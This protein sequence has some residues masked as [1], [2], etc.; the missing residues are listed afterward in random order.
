MTEP[1]SQPGSSQ[2]EE[3]P[4]GLQLNS[5]PP[6]S[7]QVNRP[8]NQAGSGQAYL[9]PAGQQL[10]YRARSLAEAHLGKIL[11]ADRNRRTRSQKA[12]QRRVKPILAYLPGYQHLLEE[13][14]RRFR[15]AKDTELGMSIAAE[16][17]LDNAYIVLQA[18]REMR[19]DLPPHY[20]YELPYLES[21]ILRGYPRVYA[22]AHDLIQHENATIDPDRIKRY[23]RAYQAVD[24]GTDPSA[25]QV[26]SLL[27]MGELWALPA[28]LRFG[29]LETLATC[30]GGITAQLNPDEPR[31]VPMLRIHKDLTGDQLVAN[32]VLSLRGLASQDWKVFFEDTSLVE[33]VLKSEPAGVYPRMDFETRDQYRKAVEQLARLTG[34]DEREVSATGSQAG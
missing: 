30:V 8:P 16:W 7:D 6:A 19:I 3:Q 28:M 1:S 17:M 13:A 31:H 5:P 2:P 23:I 21:G 26:S 24:Q 32:C 34:Q 27:S 15:G 20:Y 33:Q 14:N 29:I 12:I 18:L 9:E 11:V 22:V 25:N 4:T 10:E